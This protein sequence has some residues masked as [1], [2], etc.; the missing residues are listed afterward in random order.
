VTERYK[1][2]NTVLFNG[3]LRMDV[4][5]AGLLEHSHKKKNKLYILGNSK[6]VKL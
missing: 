4:T 6:Q 1:N 2:K 3:N 5:A